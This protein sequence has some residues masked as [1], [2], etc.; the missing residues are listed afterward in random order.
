MAIMSGAGPD[1]PGTA[2]FNLYLFGLIDDA[3][4]IIAALVN[5]SLNSKIEVQGGLEAHFADLHLCAGEKQPFHFAIILLSDAKLV[6]LDDVASNPDAKTEAK[7]MRMIEEELGNRTIMAVAHR[8]HTILDY[9]Q[10][11]VVE[12][13]AIVETYSPRKLLEMGR[14]KILGFA[15]KLSSMVTTS[16]RYAVFRGNVVGA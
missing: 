2:R 9:D 1:L 8:S 15:K 6:L 13:G 5:V 16:D 10:V 4:P 3:S 14:L 7:I 11:I 12:G